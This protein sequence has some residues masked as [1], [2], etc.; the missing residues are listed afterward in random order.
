MP[1]NLHQ[2]YL[3]GR[4]LAPQ[5]CTYRLMGY[6]IADVHPA[7]DT[8][9][10]HLP[11]EMQQVLDT[12]KEAGVIEENTR[13][14]AYFE[15]CANVQQARECFYAEMPSKFTYRDKAWRIRVKNVKEVKIGRLQLVSPFHAERFYLRLLL[16]TTRGPTS[17]EN[18][19]TG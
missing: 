13:L 16:L 11:G 2:N 14:T 15:A 6:P 9:E 17:F 19:R 10:V 12:R 8:L 7:V 3:D 5:L 4:Y 1:L 18:L